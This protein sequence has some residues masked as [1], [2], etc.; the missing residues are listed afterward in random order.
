MYF[1]H[2]CTQN[3][4]NENHLHTPQRS[5]DGC[6]T[7]ACGFDVSI[8]LAS[9]AQHT[10]V[11]ETNSFLPFHDSVILRHDKFNGPYSSVLTHSR[12]QK[13][14]VRTASRDKHG[15]VWRAIAR[16][17]VGNVRDGRCKEIARCGRSGSVV[18]ELPDVLFRPLTA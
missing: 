11:G 5:A 6:T 13:V 10:Q 1:T 3:T 8:R 17:D 7:C 2:N 14:V 12:Q 4:H 9:H 15:G 16:D 18:K